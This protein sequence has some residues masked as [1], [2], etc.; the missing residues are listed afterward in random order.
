MRRGKNA[1]DRQGTKQSMHSKISAQETH[2]FRGNANQLNTLVSDE[3]EALAG[4]LDLVDP[5]GG[6]LVELLHLVSGDHFQ[7]L[8]QLDTIREISTDFLDVRT[9]FSEV[10]VDPC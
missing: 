7:E 10:R 6:L 4:I 2:T 1:A 5:H 3:L 9:E 8:S